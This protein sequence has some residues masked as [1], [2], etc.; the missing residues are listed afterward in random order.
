[1]VGAGYDEALFAPGIKPTPDPVEL[2]YAG[3]LCHAKGL[4]WLLQALSRIK[5][6]S[7]RLHLIGGGSGEEHDAC[8]RMAQTLGDRVRSYGAIPQAKVAQCMQQAH[9][10]I[11]PSFFEGL[12]LVVLA[13]LACRCRIV[14]NRLPGGEVLIDQR[15]NEVVRLVSLPRLYAID[16]PLAADERATSCGWRRRCKP[17]WNKS[18]PAP[19]S[20]GARSKSI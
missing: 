14:A 5:A 8:L 6:P 15:M 9:I 2:L 16:R 3:K 13:A 11:L 18:F 19:R 10:F 17:K 20:T 7:W 12:P 4:P 1:V